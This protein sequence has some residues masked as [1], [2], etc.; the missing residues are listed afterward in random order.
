MSLSIV[1]SHSIIPTVNEQYRDLVT[2]MREEG[3]SIM[4][5]DMNP[6]SSAPA[7]NLL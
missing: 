4:L 3:V 6:P 1:D 2:T 5:A 7:H